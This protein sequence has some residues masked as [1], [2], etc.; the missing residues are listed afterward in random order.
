MGESGKREGA[1]ERKNIRLVIRFHHSKKGTVELDHWDVL[2]F[3][4]SPFTLSIILER[5]KRKRNKKKMEMVS[6]FSVISDF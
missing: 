6:F 3:S 2:I 1:L 4:M 5:G